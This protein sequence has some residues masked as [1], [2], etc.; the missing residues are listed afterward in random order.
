MMNQLNHYLGQVAQTLLLLPQQPLDA[1]AE[2]LWETYERDGTII[3]CG[4]GG[5]AAT[6]SHF[7]CDLMKWTLQPGMRRVRA[8]A[9]TD[10]IP[11]MTAFSNDQSYA[12]VFLEQLMTHYRPGDMLFAISG[13]GN[14]RNITN[15]VAW[16]NTQGAL[17]A[18]LSGFDG[19]L[20]ARLAR[21]SL[22]VENQHMPQVEDVHSAI[23]HAFAV[24]L[25]LRIE[26]R[27]VALEQAA[28]SEL[29]AQAVGA[30]GS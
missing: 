12:E 11:V 29:L 16:A 2:A 1:I 24:D 17:T 28:T 25:G 5:S 15:A 14:S 18:G 26:R 10:N 20:L 21:I 19:G 27:R 8:L 4:N 3:V 7:A 6:A 13:S 22:H 30:P 23:C 9:L